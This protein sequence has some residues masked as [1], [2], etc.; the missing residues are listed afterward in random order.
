[1][2]CNAEIISAITATLQKFYPGSRPVPNLVVDPVMI[3]SSGAALLDSSAI[4]TLI[5]DLLPLCFIL[6][7]N[8]P[9]AEYILANAKLENPVFTSASG[10]IESLEQMKLAAQDL[11]RLGPSIILLKGGHLPF[12]KASGK[13]LPQELFDSVDDLSVNLEELELVDLVYDARSKEY[14][15]LRKEF[16][17]TSS[18]HGTGCTLSAAIA[19][20]LSHGLEGNNTNMLAPY[21]FDTAGCERA[22]IFFFHFSS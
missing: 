19:A 14:V 10:K 13:A 2:L 22:N 16:L 7:P 18:T 11:A 3:A 21:M 6:T 5:N 1:M 17:R 8:V 4:A 15:E 20:E 9:E 12:Y